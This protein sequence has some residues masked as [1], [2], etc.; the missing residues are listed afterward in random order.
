M[1]L[2]EICLQN[3]MKSFGKT[4]VLEPLDLTVKNGEFL[5]LVGP[6]GCGKSTLLRLIAGLEQPSG[7]DILIEGR[8]ALGLSL[9]TVILP[10]SFSHML[11][12]LI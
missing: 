2:A 12:I 4:K 11:Y 7:G 5:V 6:S 1:V 3:T 8:S 9:R 10:W